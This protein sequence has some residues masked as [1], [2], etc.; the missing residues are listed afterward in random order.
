MLTIHDGVVGYVRKALSYP[1]GFQRVHI[2]LG[3]ILSFLFILIVGYA[4]AN[5]FAFALR[6]LLLSRFPLQR[7]LPFAISMVTYYVFLVL[8]FLAALVNTG[9]ELNKFTLITGALGLGVGFGLQNII[10]NFA[11]GLILLFER[12]IRVG[13]TVEMKG[14]VGT[15]SRIGA[16][17]STILTFEDAEVVVPN[18]DLISK[19]VINWTLSSVR[20]RVDIPVGV[21]YG[22]DPERMLSLLLEVA[23]SHPGV[24]VNQRQ[25]R[26]ICSSSTSLR[27]LVTP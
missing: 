2:T 5:L 15:V 10:N 14:F 9:M 8:V 21:A 11:S 17:S 13:D 25:A 24:R 7:G 4:V 6:K 26:C 27:S 20:R 16:R 22:T 1:I 19:E 18:S 3:G 23:S 12:P